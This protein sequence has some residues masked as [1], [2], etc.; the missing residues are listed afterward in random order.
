MATEG[1]PLREILTSYR[2]LEELLREERGAIVEGKMKELGP[3][4]AAGLKR[5][6]AI[7]E[8][9]KDFLTGEG[10]AQSSPEPEGA[11]EEIGQ[12]LKGLL[13]LSRQNKELM[14]ER[15]RKVGKE[16]EKVKAGQKLIRAYRP[17]REE[18]FRYL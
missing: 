2:A 18:I 5:I 6:T 10:A 1:D 14:G 3:L 16:I 9:T 4:L 13:S 8:K 11:R 15:W 12:V 17:A 7:E